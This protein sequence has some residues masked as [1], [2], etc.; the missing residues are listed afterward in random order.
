MVIKKENTGYDD[1]DITLPCLTST[2]HNLRV[3]LR[4]DLRVVASCC[5]AVQV[6]YRN[7]YLSWTGKEVNI[8][9]TPNRRNHEKSQWLLRDTLNELQEIC[10]AAF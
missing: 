1:S 9:R 2:P 5:P 7:S 8:P 10:R 4:V 3:D 6:G